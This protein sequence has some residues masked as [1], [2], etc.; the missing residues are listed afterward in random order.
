[1]PVSENRRLVLVLFPLQGHINPMLQLATILNSRGFSIT[2]AHPE[3]NSPD[4]SNYPNF[5]FLPIPDGLSKS[6]FAAQDFHSTMIAI[7][8]N[9]QEPLRRFILQTLEQNNPQGQVACIV[10]DA[11]MHFA[12]KV[13]SQLNLPSINVRTSAAASMLAFA[14]FPRADEQGYITFADSLTQ[15]ESH[16]L[17]SLE[18]R[19]LLITMGENPSDTTLELRAATTSAT[20]NSCATIVNTIQFLEEE[21]LPKIREYFHAPIFAIGP[22]HKLAPSS[23]SSLLEEDTGCISWLDKQA[24][25]SV[26]YV[27]FGSVA[28]MNEEQLLETAMG[29][30]MS[31]RPFLWVVRPS[32]VGCT[33]WVELLPKGF[34]EIIGQRGCI[35]K[36]APQKEVL[37]HGAVGGFWTH[38]GWNSTLESICEGVPMLCWPVFGD[39]VLDAKYIS[40]LWKIGLQLEAKLERGK[41]A[42]AIRQLMVEEEGEEI[43]RKAQEFKVR[44]E[45]SLDIGGSTN[46]SLNELVELILSF[47]SQHV[48][49]D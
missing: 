34:Q 48:T 37:A 14:A 30:A 40:H 27:S 23:S 5:T 7:H 49:P 33:E 24:S 46:T 17:Q 25:R 35:V 12:Q 36:W 15:D 26:L 42:R 38:C 22:F 32:S 1:M 2:I 16:K 44:A 6:S 9:C 19:D 39:Q 28:S 8:R 43:R 45:Q 13:A 18:L 47:Q 10:Y 11:V 41:I 3:F 21:T 20:R 31:E 4:P 29:L